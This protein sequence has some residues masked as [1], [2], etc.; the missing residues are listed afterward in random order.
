QPD[1]AELAVQTALEMKHLL[2]V[3]N[4][5]RVQEGKAPL[6][7]GVG[8]NTG[9][10]VVGN[11]G[12]E[13][14]L[15]YTAIGDAVNLASRLEGINKQYGTDIVIS[16][17]TY[18]CLGDHMI[19]R[20]LD[21][22]RVKGKQTPVTIYEV[23]GT[24]DSVSDTLLQFREMFTQGLTSYRQRQWDLAIQHF[25]TALQIKPADTPSHLYI[26]RCQMYKTNPPPDQ[27]DGVFEMKT[28]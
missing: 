15:E 19:E 25:Q 23:L 1:H 16:E 6:K 10:V 13:Q 21:V 11:I 5:E 9:A 18:Q 8:I 12:S 2:E 14:R 27:W 28:K 26:T 24:R 3:F 17:P 20:E 4:T 22:V 7:I